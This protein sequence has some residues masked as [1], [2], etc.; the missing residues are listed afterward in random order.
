[1]I[2]EFEQTYENDYFPYE[3]INDLIWEW[4]RQNDIRRAYLNVEYAMDICRENY[5]KLKPGKMIANAIKKLIHMRID[6]IREDNYEYQKPILEKLESLKI[7]P[8]TVTFW[9]NAIANQPKEKITIRLTYGCKGS[10]REYYHVG[11]CWWGGYETSRDYLESSYGGAI[12][13]YRN[14]EIVGRVWFIPYSDGIILFNAYGK[15]ELGRIGSWSNLLKRSFP[16]YFVSKVMLEFGGD[17]GVLF[18]N[19]EST[20]LY[21]GPNKINDETIRIDLTRPEKFKYAK[22]LTFCSHCGIPI[23]G[24]SGYSTTDNGVICYACQNLFYARSRSTGAWIP[25]ENAIEVYDAYNDRYYESPDS[26]DIIYAR[27]INR[28]VYITDYWVDVFGTAHRRGARSCFRCRVSGNIY[29]VDRLVWTQIGPVD[30]TNYDPEVH[31]LGIPEQPQYA[32]SLSFADRQNQ[33][34]LRRQWQQLTSLM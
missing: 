14:D 21:I 30:R 19:S 34:A 17:P 25:I 10:A 31:V 20:N 2:S 16:D 1:M 22:D 23:I 15:G 32:P 4:I 8:E 28:Y 12:R 11:S 6:Q 29:P 27:A 24:G 9:G 18:Q 5:G 7:S 33:M 13:A 26:P 3:Q